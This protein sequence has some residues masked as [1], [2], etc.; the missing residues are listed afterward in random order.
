MPSVPRFLLE[1]GRQGSV[2]VVSSETTYGRGDLELPATLY[3]PS[4]SD[5]LPGWVVLHG[6]STTGRQH[7]SLVRF[8]RSIAAGGNLVMVPDIPEWR[9]LR[10][11][12]AVTH[13]TIRTAVREL[14]DREDTDP[15][16]IGL[17]GFS[18][19]ATQALIAA[20]DPR[21]QPLLRGIAAWGGY[22]DIRAVCR[23]GMTGT[24]LLDGISYTEEPDPY[25]A[26]VLAGNYLTLAPGHEGDGAVAAALHDLARESGRV[27]AFAWDPV[28]D[29]YKRMLRE[30]LDASGRELFDA[31]APP[32]T[33]PPGATAQRVR[34]AEELGDTV[35][36]VDPL[37]NPAP[38]LG[39]VDVDVILAHG[40]DDRLVPFTETIRTAR[41]LPAASVRDCT[42]TELFDH[43]GHRNRNLGTA[44]TLA[45]GYRFV[46][47]LRRILHLL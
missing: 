27:G 4:G 17:F 1:Y 9:D 25:G 47:L 21:V 7:P 44:G 29:P 26:W 43:S 31:I 16:R 8:A 24:H 11:E 39:S 12:P 19:G 5:R 30:R 20:A 41:A 36:R 34:L 28:Y 15:D 14:H 46:R 18:F 33:A 38:F 3:R 10:I 2:G 42:I 13:E 22:H 45:E 23:F 37:M 32:T 40:R 35:V 6:L